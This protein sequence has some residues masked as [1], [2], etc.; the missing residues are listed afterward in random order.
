MKGNCPSGYSSMQTQMGM[1]HQ[2]NERERGKFK[3]LGAA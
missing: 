2:S 1:Q 3:V